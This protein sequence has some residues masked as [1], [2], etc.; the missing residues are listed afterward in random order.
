LT[1]YV[2]QT[3]AVSW[4]IFSPFGLGLYGAFGWAWLMA[5]ALAVNALLLWAANGWLRYYR[6]APVEWAWR[7]LVEVRRLPFRRPRDGLPRVTR[8]G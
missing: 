2:A 3:L 6:I 4:L 8:R 7:S 5:L 1:L